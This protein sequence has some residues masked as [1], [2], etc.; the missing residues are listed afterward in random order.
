MSL[1]LAVL[2]VYGAAAGHLSGRR[3]CMLHGKVYDLITRDDDADR[4][5]GAG[6]HG[7][8]HVTELSSMDIL[9]RVSRTCG[10]A[11][12]HLCAGFSLDSSILFILYSLH[13]KINA[14]I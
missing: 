3:V 12:P 13:P 14:I 4:D 11:P 7:L 2:L 8:G 1:R 10:H 6:V 5:S 9:C